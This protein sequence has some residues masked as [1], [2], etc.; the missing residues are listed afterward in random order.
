VSI[1]FEQLRANRAARRAGEATPPLDLVPPVAD[2]PE[3]APDPTEPTELPDPEPTEPPDHAV[4]EAAPVIVP[5]PEPTEEPPAAPAAPPAPPE[6]QEPAQPRIGEVTPVPAPLG[7][8][9]LRRIQARDLEIDDALRRGALTPPEA[10]RWRET[11]DQAPNMAGSFT[12]ALRA[13]PNE[14]AIPLTELGR[15][16]E[17]GDPE[18]DILYRQIFGRN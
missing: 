1:D 3:P 6:P 4:A 8:D 2:E 10:Q 18:A 11:F 15:A 17:R 13:L 12:T 7:I 14:R 16:D 9:E 5:G